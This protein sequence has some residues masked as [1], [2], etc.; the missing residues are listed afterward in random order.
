MNINFNNK[1][2][3]REPK[4]TITIIKTF[5]NNYGYTIQ[6]EI[7]QSEGSTWSS[8]IKLFFNNNFLYSTNGKGITKEYCLASGY[9][10][11][12]ERFC[13]K[14][15]IISNPILYEKYIN[16]NYKTNKYYL[17][18]DEKELTLNDLLAVPLYNDYFKKLEYN[19]TELIKFLQI[20]NG[21][22]LIGQPYVNFLT[23]N[24]KY[25]LNTLNY[26]LI[27]STGL[28]SGN[29]LE[30]AL[31][32]GFSEYCERIVASKIFQEKNKEFGKYCIIDKTETN[33][34]NQKLIEQIELND[35]NKI[36]IFDFSY[37][38]NLPV[39]GVLL[40]NQKSNLSL[41][42]LGSF[43]DFDLALERCLTEIYQNISTFTKPWWNFSANEFLR[44]INNTDLVSYVFTTS[45]K[46]CNVLPDNLLLNS[47]QY[48]KNKNIWINYEKN[49]QINENNLILYYYKLFTQL[50][51]NF[52][53][54]DISLCKEIYTVHIICEDV[55]LQ[56][57]LYHN[58]DDIPVEEKIDY[59][60]LFNLEKNI[61]IQ[62]LNNQTINSI[63]YAN[64]IKL[65]KQHSW[66]I[67]N[68]SFFNATIQASWFRPYKFY[69][70]QFEELFELIINSPSTIDYINYIDGIQE[71]DKNLYLTLLNL[72]LKNKFTNN[73]I[74][75]ILSH[76]NNKLPESL[77]NNPFNQSEL[78]QYFI[79]NDCYNQYNEEKNVLNLVIN[80]L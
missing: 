56:D 51:L 59:L 27:R 53:I 5:F 63:D 77:I 37:N 54:K 4:E 70:N 29:T 2:K 46:F 18:Q 73:E 62:L 39:C 80:K 41:L 40:F 38:F 52:Y 7:S 24:K 58:F 9:G 16:N 43:P 49:N 72:K 33:N 8:V 30:E 79:L 1:Y 6:E 34:N 66:D 71:L 45:S 60:Q 50:N 48:I 14:I 65:Y 19:E 10:E 3:N 23:K 36:I 15:H 20:I 31:I 25:F 28:A 11:L 35:N 74:K 12:Y 76:F 68:Y 42:N 78:I 13:S 61:I 44:N 67:P 32:Q 69:S 21:E 64:L 57:C 75:K 26:R 17:E 22:K 55:V 47:Y